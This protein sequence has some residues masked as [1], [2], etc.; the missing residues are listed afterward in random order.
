MFYHDS[1]Y[2]GYEF[3]LAYVGFFS[4]L[5]F[6]FSRSQNVSSGNISAA[7]TT[8]AAGAEYAG[9]IN[10]QNT[11]LLFSLSQAMALLIQRSGPLLTIPLLR[12]FW[13]LLDIIPTIYITSTKFSPQEF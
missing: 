6:Y 2:I 9:R 7:V 1:T 10:A 12:L 4:C 8:L 3:Q 13:S 11:R 5:F